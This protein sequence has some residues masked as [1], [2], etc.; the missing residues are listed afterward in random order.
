MSN[1][2]FIKDFGNY[3]EGKINARNKAAAKDTAN[4]SLVEY[5]DREIDF[6][7]S[8]EKLI[9]AN[10]IEEDRK[11]A[12]AKQASFALGIISGKLEKETGRPHPEY[13]FQLK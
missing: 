5:L 3:I 10:L 1:E 11:Q 6:L 2:R 9:I 7:E 8:C 4:S 12:K 13:L